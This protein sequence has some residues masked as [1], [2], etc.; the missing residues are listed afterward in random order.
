MWQVVIK[1]HCHCFRSQANIL[2]IYPEILASLTLVSGFGHDKDIATLT[3]SLQVYHQSVSL[4]TLY[5]QTQM[6]VE[7]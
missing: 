7:I 5:I 3:G 6:W 1:A 4:A 2:P